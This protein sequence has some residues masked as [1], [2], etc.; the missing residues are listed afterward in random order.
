[1]SVTGVV[2]FF[3]WEPGLTT[4]V[5]QWMSWVFLLAVATHVAINV[6]PFKSH[7]K[8]LWGRGSI[9]IFGLLLA[10]SFY[11][12]GLITGP[13]M[14][15]RIELALVEARLA[16]LADVTRTEPAELVRR[17]EA[18]GFVAS[19]DQSIHDLVRAYGVDEN[20]LLAIVFTPERVASALP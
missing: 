11:H 18:N 17:F 12:W 10:V 19:A 14:K 13:Q 4:V 20:V 1:M 5:H 15:D 8:S 9:A 2:M 7:L 3:D 16:A 6:R